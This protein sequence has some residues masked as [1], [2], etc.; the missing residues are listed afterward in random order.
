M[1]T[2]T[3]LAI[4]LKPI[5]LAVFFFLVVAPIAWLLYRAFPEGRLKVILFRN[6]SGPEAT[7]RDKRVMVYSVIG[8]YLAFFAWLW[9]RD[10]LDIRLM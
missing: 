9:I 5:I 8:A 10:Y 6:R 7:D 4:L 3:V 1:E 2:T